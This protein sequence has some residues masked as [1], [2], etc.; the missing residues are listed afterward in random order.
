MCGIGAIAVRSPDPRIEALAVAMGCAQAHRGPDNQAARLLGGGRAALAHARLSIVDLSPLGN[1][2][3]SNEDGSVWVVCNGEIYNYPELRAQLETRGHRFRSNSDTETIVHLYEEYG[4]AL[5]DHLHGMFA[6]ALYDV[7]GDRLL[8]ARD[9][10]GKKPLVFAEIPGGVAMASELPVLM[11]AIGQR[12]LDAT[13]LGMFFL[14]NV[15]HVPDPMTIYQGV[16]RLMPGHAMVV[17]HGRI[18]RSWR[19][20]RPRFDPQPTTPAQVL[21][22]FDRAVAMRRVA[23]VEVG[24]LL[25]GGVDSSAIVEAM[26]RLGSGKVRTYAMG[27]DAND[28]ELVRARRMA[29]LLKTE[30][31]EFYFDPDR[32]HEHF[33]LMLARQGEPI[34]LLPLGYTYEL[35]RHIRDDGIRVVMTG[36]GADEIFYGYPGHNATGTLSRLLPFV[37]AATQPLLRR[38]AS[39]FAPGSRL[40]EALLV[41]GSPAGD[42]KAALYRDEARRTWSTLLRSPDL[43]PS[44]DEVMGRWLGTWFEDGAPDAYVDEASILGLMHENAH[45]VTIAGDLPAMA[46]SVEARAPFLDQTLVEHAW[47]IHFDAKIGGRFQ[48]AQNKLILKRALADRLPADVL[49]APKKGFGYH[50]QEADVLRGPWRERVRRA[51][52]EGNDLNGLLDM[53]QARAIERAF[54]DGNGAPAIL[55]AKLY[56]A[57][58]FGELASASRG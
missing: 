47:R 44:V 1:Q 35:C 58:R 25:S 21:A 7:R 24:A 46:A 51:F 33:E 41:A 34:M 20:W 28:D 22:E 5:M 18:A 39:R 43:V 12:E 55:V 23:D 30:H 29:R 13:A 8:C 31:R 50:I 9:R 37:P 16:H 40:R 36:H 19:Y 53:D 2:P 54:Y 15:R 52:C 14:R 10:L 27:Q 3:M 56:A 32:Q 4:D 42:R 6:F 48:R 38:A 11:Q 45:S 26:A 57:M 17:E 49:Y